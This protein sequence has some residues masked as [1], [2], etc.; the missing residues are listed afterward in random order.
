MP[1]KDLL[2]GWLRYAAGDLI[3]AKHMLEDVYP[4]W[5]AISAWHS[6]QCAEKALKSVLVACDIDPPKIHNLDEPV[7]RCRNIDDCFSE[8]QGDC[9][10]LNPYGAATRYPNG[11]A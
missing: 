11:L 1:D 10:K 7:K 4:K 3:A 8:I 9:Q 5:T 2:A 6:Q